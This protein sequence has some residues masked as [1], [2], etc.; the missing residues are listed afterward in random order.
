MVMTYE[1]GYKNAKINGNFKLMTMK[2][3]IYNFEYLFLEKRKT[4]ASQVCLM[5]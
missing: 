4:L 3:A 2:H 5:L 1:V